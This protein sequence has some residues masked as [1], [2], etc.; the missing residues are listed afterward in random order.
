MSGIENRVAI[1]NGRIVLSDRIIEGKSVLITDGR[2]TAIAAADEYNSDEFSSI[3]AGGAYVTP[4]LIDI[5]IHGCLHHTFNDP[6]AEAFE[7]ILKK[8]LSC[9]VTTLQP[10]L[11]SAPIDDLCRVLA[12]IEKWKADQKIGLTQIRGAYLESPYIAPPAAGA[13]PASTI[14]TPDDGTIDRL[15][16]FHSAISV[17]ML[18]PELPGAIAAIKKIASSGIIAAMGH[19]MAI[20]KEILPAID[21]GASH[22][23]HLWS[24]MSGVVRHGPWRQPGLVEVTLTNPALT[25]EIIA[26]NRHLPPTL[27]KLAIQC[28]KEQLCAV[29]DALNGAGLPEGSKFRV[30]DQIYEVA[31]GVGMVPDRSSFAGSTTLLNREIPVLIQEAGLS[32]PEAVRIVTEIPA[33]IMKM[34]E[35]IGSIKPGLDADIVL[36]SEDFAPVQVIQKGQ[37]MRIED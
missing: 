28:K 4:G 20:E 11:V 6:S 24:A 34:D 36:F 31:D 25:T 1:Q 15:M 5:H 2:I 27:M 12:F 19:T 16:D 17:F 7:T 33:G 26:D 9:G 21:A 37:P 32:I 13:Q 8:T 18:A 3:D 23:T 29:S 30:G 10:T 22:V 14:R 35:H